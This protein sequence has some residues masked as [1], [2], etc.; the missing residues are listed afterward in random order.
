MNLEELPQGGAATTITSPEELEI[1]RK[2][3]LFFFK[4]FLFLLQRL[5]FVQW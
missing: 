4:C 5:H 3:N 1:L 2:H